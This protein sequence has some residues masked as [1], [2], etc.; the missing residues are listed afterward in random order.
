MSL[1]PYARM[2][3]NDQVKT[4]CILSEEGSTQGDVAAM[5]MYAIGI[6]P[7]IDLLHRNTD[8]WKCQQVWYAD[9]SSSAGHLSEIRSWW[10]LLNEAGPKFGYHP[11]ATKTILIVK[12]KKNLQ[13]AEEIFKNT[14]I[15]ITHSGER[16]LGAVIGSPEFRAEYVESKVESWIDD[17]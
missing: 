6:R 16:H 5:A 8:N 3:I 1:C 2:I 14:N 4:D 13:L 11:K 15:K 10:D 9:D 7:L 17:I 12:D